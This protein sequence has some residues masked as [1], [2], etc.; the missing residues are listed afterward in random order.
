MHLSLMSE[1]LLLKHAELL[2]EADNYRLVAKL[3]RSCAVNRA[4]R[5]AA[6]RRAEADSR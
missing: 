1:L 6:Q 5:R 4:T 2:Q 3:R